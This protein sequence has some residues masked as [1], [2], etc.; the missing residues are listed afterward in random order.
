MDNKI[1]KFVMFLLLV[2][3]VSLLYTIVDTYPWNTSAYDIGKITGILFKHLIKIFG[4][5]GLV[6][7]LIRYVKK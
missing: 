5:A 6:V 1:K 2:F 3:V 4:L 7:L